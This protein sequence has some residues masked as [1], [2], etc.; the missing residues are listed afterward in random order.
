MR[1][2]KRV[3]VENSL[4]HF[5]K[6]NPELK[7]LILFDAEGGN[8]KKI[9][10]AKKGESGTIAVQ[11]PFMSYPEMDAYLMGY[12][13]K[14]KAV[15]GPV[16]ELTARITERFDAYEVHP[17]REISPGVVEQCDE[18]EQPDFW[19]VYIHLVSGGLQCIADCNSEQDAQALV[20]ILLSAHHN[21]VK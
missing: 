16:I 20:D 15:S 3:D 17:C 18:G 7:S 9:A 6:E 5:T 12:A 1:K 11:S 14:R 4:I 19:S 2:A 8:N 21:I 10:L 13:A